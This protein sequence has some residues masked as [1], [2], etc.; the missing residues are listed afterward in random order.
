M[1]TNATVFEERNLGA[2]YEPEADPKNL[3][4]RL[5]D[6]KWSRS[7]TFP[8]SPDSFTEEFMNKPLVKS[9]HTPT[10]PIRR[11][12]K[13]T[14]QG[15]GNN[16]GRLKR[17]KK[18]LK[19]SGDTWSLSQLSSP[20][21]SLP[22]TPTSSL[23][24][25]ISSSASPTRFRP[26][27]RIPK[28][29][30]YRKIEEDVI[31]SPPKDVPIITKEEKKQETPPKKQSDESQQDKLDQKANIRMDRERHKIVSRD[32]I[33][34]NDV[35]TLATKPIFNRTNLESHT[36]AT[37]MATPRITLKM[38]FNEF[39]NLRN[40]Q[41]IQQ[42]QQQTTTHPMEIPTSGTENAK[43]RFIPQRLYIHELDNPSYVPEDEKYAYKD[44]GFS[45][46]E[47]EEKKKDVEM[48]KHNL[49]MNIQKLK[50]QP[51]ISP[52]IS[53]PSTTTPQPRMLPS[54]VS[55]V[56]ANGSRVAENNITRS[57]NRK[58][59]FEQPSE[60]EIIRE[61]LGPIIGSA[62]PIEYTHTR[63]SRVPAA[64]DVT[65][66]PGST[67]HQQERRTIRNQTEPTV[68]VV[69]PQIQGQ[70]VQHMQQTSNVV[71]D[72]EHD[73]QMQRFMYEQQNIAAKLQNY[74]KLLDDL[75]KK[76]QHHFEETAKQHQRSLKE[77]TSN[78]SVT[79]TQTVN[80]TLA[81]IHK[82]STLFYE[83]FEQLQAATQKATKSMGTYANV[84]KR[85]QKQMEENMK[86]AEQLSSKLHNIET[87]TQR[88]LSLA[89][90]R[91]ERN[92]NKRLE[93]SVFGATPNLSLNLPNVND[94]KLDL[95]KFPDLLKPPGWTEDATADTLQQI[96]NDL[97]AGH[98]KQL[99]EKLLGDGERPD[100]T[101]VFKD[102]LDAIEKM[103]KQIFEQPPA[104][105][106]FIDEYDIIES[107]LMKASQIKDKKKQRE[108]PIVRRPEVAVSSINP[109]VATVPAQPTMTFSELRIKYP[110]L[111]N[112][113]LKFS[114]LSETERKARQEEKDRKRVEEEQKAEE[115]KETEDTKPI[116]QEHIVQEAP[117]VQ[118]KP[119]REVQEVQ[120]QAEVVEIKE[121]EHIMSS[122]SEFSSQLARSTAQVQTMP[123]VGTDQQI[124]TSAPTT[125]RQLTTESELSPFS[126]MLSQS[127]KVRQNTP[128]SPVKSPSP[129]PPIRRIVEVVEKR[130]KSPPKVR[131]TS[132]TPEEQPQQQQPQQAP[133]LEK[134]EIPLHEHI[135]LKRHDGANKSAMQA[136]IDVTR[137][138]E[139]EKQR[140]QE[141]LEKRLRE[142]QE[143]RARRR[144]LDLQFVIDE[145]KSDDQGDSTVMGIT[146]TNNRPPK[147]I[148]E[149]SQPSK[150]VRFAESD[151]VALF[152]DSHGIVDLHD[153]EK[154]MDQ[155]AE[156]YTQKC[157]R[158]ISQH[159]LSEYL[160]E[161]TSQYE[162]QN[163]EELLRQLRPQFDILKG[164]ILSGELLQFII[165]NGISLHD[166]GL[167]QLI[168]ALVID[169]ITRVLKGLE[170]EWDDDRARGLL[171]LLYDVPSLEGELRRSEEDI[172]HNII[173][174]L[175]IRDIL[176]QREEEKLIRRKLKIVSEEPR[177]QIP[178][179]AEQEEPVI[180]V[181]ET[182]SVKETSEKS[183]S[184]IIVE[185][186]TATVSTSPPP[187]PE[188]APP[189]PHYDAELQVDL[190]PLSPIKPVSTAT[191]VQT[192]S[193]RRQPRLSVGFPQF[194]L[195][196]MHHDTREIPQETRSTTAISHQP[197]RQPTTPPPPPI[198][199]K[200][201]HREIETQTV[202]AMNE[203]AQVQ[204]LTSSVRRG[205]VHVQT[206]VPESTTTA[207]QT[208]ISIEELQN[209]PEKA[210]TSRLPSP[211]K[212]PK[213]EPAQPSSTTSEEEQEIITIPAS[214]RLFPYLEESRIE[215]KLRLELMQGRPIKSYLYR[216]YGESDDSVSTMS[217]QGTFSTL[218]GEPTRK[219]E[220]EWAH[221]V[222]REAKNTAM[223]DAFSDD[224]DYSF[225]HYEES[226]TDD[227]DYSYGELITTRKSID[228]ISSGSSDLSVL[229]HHMEYE[230]Q[231][232]RL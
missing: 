176:M 225:S 169:C 139:I 100:H 197:I 7:N 172:L 105:E 158:F 205:E 149:E 42:Q 51:A 146:Y 217:S 125:P 231:E 221:E 111:S 179:M 122:T 80:K 222:L 138:K 83:Q 52:K 129:V 150:H 21:K 202:K 81:D 22:P 193:P 115:L 188:K 123:Q 4:R 167:E 119:A 65:R 55:N 141:E 118:Q 232:E 9:P 3:L 29:Q 168:E 58:I 156:K 201:V 132:P 175:V 153:T 74:T 72:S 50:D 108:R 25:S 127:G 78:V 226:D 76:A 116:Q 19:S 171:S 82:T 136:K 85:L 46:D 113:L 53:A 190:R 131:T 112:N 110:Q 73:Y 79:I 75:V 223:Y 26:Q 220:I 209:E 134:I 200:P 144:A 2:N 170:P 184:P 101:K 157:M 97:A 196:D 194:F 124:Q 41:K 154:F 8:D 148:K 44:E 10:S 32:L 192:E 166:P 173:I 185:K 114:V 37:T 177:P 36:R 174:K 61:D 34:V 49:I 54:N 187:S 140:R 67:V 47:E 162:Y 161:M 109:Y 93:Q 94:P 11:R 126:L 163:V 62:I 219:E 160:N 198:I 159:L 213:Q 92:R 145:V 117:P 98:D 204:T 206:P 214:K 57:A 91:M 164:G 68:S 216:S 96:Y 35:N 99:L 5:A 14:Q 66:A 95:S 151:S 203:E 107:A 60:R 211:I 23:N 27:Q 18:G 16:L 212:K 63:T 224:G 71:E 191:H 88:S 40:R 28:Y 227:D 13:F 12:S 229:E 77:T 142:E 24:S 143:A 137:A 130:E 182:P 186:I 128:Q 195:S 30:N 228:S 189:I 208:G 152:T 87:K 102:E 89:Q 183:T 104:F 48:M 64:V 38:D 31:V 15:T 181:S 218:S 86:R 178:V 84:D 210:T 39:Y 45:S 165:D 155:L 230:T 17:I 103:K 180:V 43:E 69:P 56:I 90:S 133:A 59:I 33:I 215:R 121:Q 199:I 135:K 70:P 147:V 1:E 106:H 207:I 6:Q 120:V 20:V